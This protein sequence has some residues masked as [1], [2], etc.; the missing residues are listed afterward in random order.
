MMLK[1]IHAAI[2]L[3]IFTIL[4][5]ASCGNNQN[6]DGANVPLTGS[7]TLFAVI[8]DS[9]NE[10][11]VTRVTIT[12]TGLDS[13]IT[14]DLTY[15]SGT[16]RWEGTVDA[17]PIGTN[18]I[19]TADA[20][21]ASDTHLYTGQVTGITVSSLNSLAVHIILGPVTPPDN[22][23]NHVPVIQS[24]YYPG[25]N[26]MLKPNETMNMFVVA[27]DEDG[28]DISYAWTASAGSF[29]QPTNLRTNYTAPASGGLVDITIT[30][31]DSKAQSNSYTYTFDI[32]S[33]PVISSLTADNNPVLVENT[34]T[35]TVAAADQE[36]DSFSYEWSCAS[37]SFEN[38]D[39]AAVRWTAPDTAGIYQINVTVTDEHNYSGT[40]NINISV[41]YNVSDAGITTEFNNWPQVTSM[42]AANPQLSS[43]NLT[44]ALT[45]DISDLNGDSL[46]YSWTSSC[47]GSFVDSSAANTD[48]T[49]DPG[50][51]QGDFCELA[52]TVE[53]GKGGQALSKLN[54]VHKDI[55][56]VPFVDEDLVQVKTGGTSSRGGGFSMSF[57][58]LITDVGSFHMSI[59]LRGEM[60]GYVYSGGVVWYDE[61]VNIRVGSCNFN[62]SYADTNSSTFRTA[63]SRVNGESISNIDVT[64]CFSGDSLSL[65]FNLTEEAYGDA[66][67]TLTHVIE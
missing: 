19:F 6:G 26:N 8:P 12:V 45:T 63:R 1:Q 35:L 43:N 51:S 22:F 33:A 29:S 20:Y 17:I 53:D 58:D 60:D 13:P 67:V 41:E 2:F 14:R 56:Y 7:G 16:S 42:I 46:S 31:T 52:L 36:S 4:T 32:N 40:A 9:L 25:N 65:Y 57:S 37:G 30:V 48:F 66:E 24:V 21:D 47:A 55:A 59:R 10:S 61:S 38:S 5:I 3:M 27:T 34:V 11:Q 28:D 18:R 64:A 44:T 15:N 62:E 39:T 50:L 49:A 23:E 54:I